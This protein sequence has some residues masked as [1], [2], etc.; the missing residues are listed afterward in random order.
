MTVLAGEDATLTFDTTTPKRYRLS[1]ESG[2]IQDWEETDSASIT[3]H[4]S[5]NT[6]NGSP[7]RTMIVTFDDGLSLKFQTYIVVSETPLVVMQNSFM[8]LEQAIARASSS[9]ATAGIVESDMDAF[10][11]AMADAF[12]AIVGMNFYIAREYDDADKNKAGYNIPDYDTGG[13]TDFRSYSEDDFSSLDPAFQNAVKRA[14]I[15][16]AKNM[17]DQRV[18]DE[19]EYNPRKDD[20]D[21]LMEKIGDTSRTWKSR[22]S[23]NSSIGVQ[24]MRALA[25]YVWSPVRTTRI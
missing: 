25:G 20:P 19:A 6:L 21:L 24:A 3:I 16:A 22:K 17:I 7:T 12:D 8:T 1:D 14:Q 9:F 13:I 10:I 4:G 2:L 15:L 11:I 5:L 23:V 18:A